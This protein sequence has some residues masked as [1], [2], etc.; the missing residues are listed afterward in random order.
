MGKRRRK[1][2]LDPVPAS[3][4]SLS[5]EGRGVAHVEG[6]T[7]FIRNALPGE[8]VLFKYKNRRSKMDEGYSVEILEASPDRIQPG[9]QH[10]D[11]CGGC[12]LQHLD[13]NQ[14]LQHKQSVL[15]EQL[16]HIGQVEP[17]SIIPPLTGP[18]WAYRNKARLGVKHVLKKDKLLIG[19]REH[20][21]R[22]IADLESCPVLHPGVGENINKLRE[23]ISG[24]SNYNQIPQLEV[25][26][27]DEYIVLIIRYLSDFNEADL[28]RLRHFEQEEGIHFY[29]QSGGPNTV[30]PL[31][32]STISQRAL[33]YALPAHDIT[34]YFNPSNFTQVNTEINRRMIDRV[35]D[36]LQLNAEDVILDLF[37]GLGNFTLPVARYCRS[38][39][40]VELLESLVLQARDNAE[41]NN[42]SNAEFITMDLAGE[43]LDAEFMHR[44]FNKL[45][46]DPARSGA[47][48]ILKKLPLDEVEL[49]VYVS[50]NPATLARDSGILVN[51]RGFKLVEAGIMDMF[52]HTAHVE[53]LAVFTRPT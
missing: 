36:R 22:Y 50:C 5:H 8:E 41:R 2:P 31:T 17:E 10:F 30:K 20:F 27:G 44:P 29:L 24:L 9:C 37:C 49:I 18:Q 43:D 26:I 23:L 47:D 13:S 35:I 3:I 25:A 51:E 6:K 32:K 14:Q 19:F 16:Q 53:S 7:T 52:P 39:I 4:E 45:L 15:L 33:S 48:V 11:I 28:D 42:I 12:S 38:I 46:L 1:L 40:G 34:I 21:S